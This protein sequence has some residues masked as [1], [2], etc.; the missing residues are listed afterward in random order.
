ME[1]ENDL[2]AA[3][4][5]S[6]MQAYIE[7]HI[8]EPITAKQLA[9]EAG[10]SQFHAARL[11]K[12]LTGLPPF[13][14]I[15]SRRLTLAALSLRDGDRRVLDVALDFVFDSHEGFTRAFAHRFGLTPSEYRSAPPPIRLFLPYR[16]DNR[17]P[18]IKEENTME[19][20]AVFVQIMER[21]KRKLLVRRGVKATE[22]FEYCEEVGCDVWEILSSVKEALYEPVGIWLPDS[23]IPKGTSKYVQGVE[24]PLDY[25]G[26]VPD[27]YE[28]CELPACTLMVFQGEPYDD[29]DFGAAIGEVQEHIERFKPEVYGYRYAKDCLRLQLEPVGYR[30]YIECLSVEKA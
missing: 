11:F 25:A 4:A 10:Y 21:P 7:R 26:A 6:R 20:K 2:A 3:R 18:K 5:V 9:D 17:F 22:Y 19:T 12:R 27:G 13:E 15:R 1:T 30:G 28:L 14:Y 8:A 16:V 24:L 29:S 23:Y